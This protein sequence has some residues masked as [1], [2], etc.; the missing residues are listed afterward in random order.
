MS[1]KNDGSHKRASREWPEQGR[2]VWPRDLLALGSDRPRAIKGR[3]VWGLLLI[4]GGAAAGIWLAG[5]G[6]SPDKKANANF[7]TSGSREADQRASQRM[8]QAEQL[9]GSGEGAGESGVKK[10]K[11][12]AGGGDTN[13]GAIATEKLALFDRLGGEAGISNIVMDFTARVIDD[14]RVNWNRKG[15]TRG[16]FSIHRGKSETWNPTPEHVAL[17]Q[18]HLIEFLALATGGPAQY[19]GKQIE[20]AHENMHISNPEFDATMGD[21]KASLDKLKVPNTEQKEL[22]AIVESTRPQIVTER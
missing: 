18:K 20:S 6:S 3:L 17:L 19:T 16:G 13:K 10:A 1:Y 8:A 21:L 2:G 5:C 22:L 4:L 12:A 7:F 9:S 14:P 15:V 11:S